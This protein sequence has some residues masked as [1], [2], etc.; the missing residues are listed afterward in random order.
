MMMI[1]T[2]L[3]ILISFTCCPQTSVATKTSPPALAGQLT[4]RGLDL[5][6]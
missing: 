2:L 6:I 3:A 4:L 1:V 5:A